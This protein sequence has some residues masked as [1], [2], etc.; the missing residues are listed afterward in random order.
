MDNDKYVQH[1]RMGAEEDLAAAQDL[2]QTKRYRHAL[3]FGHLALEKLFKAHLTK[4]T[5]TP[6]PKTHDLDFLARKSKLAISAEQRDF[7]KRM[8]QFQLEGRYPNY[9]ARVKPGPTE[10]AEFLT[11][12]RA[13]FQWL[14]RQL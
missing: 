4:I 3:F 10:T 13:L 6:P 8:D 5:G 12:T 14:I 7:I 9:I 11:N 2:F 1:W